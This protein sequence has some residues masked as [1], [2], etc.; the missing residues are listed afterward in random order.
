MRLRK[1]TMMATVMGLAIPL[2]SP[3]H[4]DE[5]EENTRLYEDDAWYDVSEW[6][7]GNDYNPTDEAIG[8]WDNETYDPAEDVGTDQDNDVDWSDTDYGYAQNDTADNDWYYDYYQDDYSDW[9]DSNNDGFYEY[10]T[11][12]YDTDNDGIYDA[13]ASFYDTDGDGVYEDSSYFFF[14]ETNALTNEQ[15]KRKA[16]SQQ[17][18]RRSERVEMQGKIASMKKIETPAGENLIV[19]LDRQ[20][21]GQSMKV[22]LGPAKAFA[23]MPAAGDTISAEGP[24][25]VI[26]DHTILLAQ[27]ATVNDKEMEIDRSN[28]RVDGKIVGT[29][30]GDVLGT[31]HLFAK[32]ETKEG[33]YCMVDM[34]PSESIQEKLSDGTQ[35][36]VRGPAVRV[37]DR[38]LI[39]ADSFTVDGEKTNVDRTMSLVN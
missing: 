21:D 28:R 18:T 30:E 24:K 3:G 4:A 7:D 15:N 20:Q 6:F 35:V 31:A 25:I 34:G 5:W 16:R 12:Y 19:Q 8:R 11:Q 26:G 33:K 17:K 10:S 1:L 36:E 22:D 27:K 32:L 37:D 23:Q 29:K 9:E 14:T 2:A 38:R 13:Y 39:M